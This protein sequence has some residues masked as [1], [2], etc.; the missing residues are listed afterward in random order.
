[1]TYFGILSQTRKP[2]KIAIAINRSWNI[3]NFRKGIVQRLLAD[4]H[5][6]LAIAPK[7]DYTQKLVD[8][9]CDFEPLE[10]EGTS[11]NPLREI[12]TILRLRRILR[13]HEVQML[14]T[15]TIKC[16][17]YGTL[18]AR[19]LG[20]PCICNVSGLGTVFLWRGW[21]STVAKLLYRMTFRFSSF[22]F[23]QNQ[24]D[25]EDFLQIIPVNPNKTGLVPGSG[26][27]LADFTH[28]KY[29]PSDRPVFLMISRL[30]IEKG[31]YEFAEAARIV[32]SKIDGATFKLVGGLDLG[33]NRSINPEDLDKWQE[34]GTVRY[35]PH[36]DNIPAFIEE[37][38][39]IVLPSYREGTPRTLLE[40]GAMS[41][42]LIATDVPGC[43]QVVDNGGNGFLC[44]VRDGEDLA[45]ALMTF[46]GLSD[47]QKK[48][49]S[50][51]SR[52]K[53]EKTFDERHVVEI[54]LRKINEL[55]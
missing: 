41:R 49:M 39:A 14:L 8:W 42:P 21:V 45:R 3:Y 10:M 35:F 32:R 15:Y 19:S 29:N 40:G 51:R 36:S 5:D 24:E 44:K 34:E 52:E 20:V 53:I 6:V 33:H 12:G 48:E 46:L 4:G 30:L 43:R 31:V 1:M 2:L 7:D 28:E 37:A 26:I 54:Y 47:T 22:I 18:A 50:V 11:T 38:D 27:N 23:F 25:R 16:N 55:A 17:I 9:G 13:R